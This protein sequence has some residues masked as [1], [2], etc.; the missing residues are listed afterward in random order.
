VP[1]TLDGGCTCGAVRYRLGSPPM[2]VHCCHCRDCQRQTGS[3]F[4]L[5]AL[6]EADRVSVLSGEPEMVAVPTDSGRAQ[7]VYRC[8]ACKIAVWSVYGGVDKLNFVR[9]GTLDDPAALTPNVHIYVRSKLPW[10]KLP[11]GVP[12]FDAYY[13]AKKLWPPASLERRRAILG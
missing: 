11:E 1:D 3:A 7:K 4:V 9:I 13:D 12:A 8:P 6:I 10:V 5:N 2:I